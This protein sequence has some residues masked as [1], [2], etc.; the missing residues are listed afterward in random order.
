LEE[1]GK[2]NKFKRVFA[3]SA[4]C[5]R[6]HCDI[7]KNK[8]NAEP[9]LNPRKNFTAQKKGS[10]AFR[11]LV[12]KSK[13]PE[14]REE[15]SLRSRIES[16]MSAVKRLFTEKVRSRNEQG[17][18]NEILLIALNYNITILIK[19]IFGYEFNVGFLHKEN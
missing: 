18:I 10:S 7:V 11:D 17:R 13:T 15:Y 5:S 1:S 6:E 3:D 14:W 9:F 12:I 4:Y 16:V 8:Y 2:T 19:A